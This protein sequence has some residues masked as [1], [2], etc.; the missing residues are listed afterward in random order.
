MTFPTPYVVQH[1][2]FELGAVPDSHGNY[3]EGWADPVALPVIAIAP[4]AMAEPLQPNRDLSAVLFSLYCPGGTSVGE[5][6][7]ITLDGTDYDVEARPQDFTRGPWQVPF[8][9]VVIYLK[10]VEG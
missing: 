3:E 4:G 5:R 10:S 6:D 9:G 2:V 8:A 7:L 1:R